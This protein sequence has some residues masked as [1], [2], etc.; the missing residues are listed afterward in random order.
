MFLLCLFVLTSQFFHLPVGGDDS[1]GVD[2]DEYAQDG[3][4]EGEEA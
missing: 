1:G 3:D 2:G 4:N